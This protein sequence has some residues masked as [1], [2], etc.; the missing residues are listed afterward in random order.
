MIDELAAFTTE[1]A[2]WQLGSES[3]DPGPE[4]N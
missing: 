4:T 2:R 3:D 1:V